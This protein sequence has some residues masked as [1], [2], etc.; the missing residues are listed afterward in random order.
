MGQEDE[1]EMVFLKESKRTSETKIWGR[2]R[3]ENGE[4]SGEGRGGRTIGIEK[5][6]HKKNEKSLKTIQLPLAHA[7]TSKMYNIQE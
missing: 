4:C 5:N 6:K 2:R 7:D 1:E 3:R